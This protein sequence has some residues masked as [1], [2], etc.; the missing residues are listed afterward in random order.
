MPV[1]LAAINANIPKI[2]LLLFL[3]VLLVAGAV[4]GYLKG[5]WRW[6][7]P[8]QVANLKALKNLQ[9]TGLELPGW[10]TL[11]QAV[12]PVSGH[13]WS[14]QQ[15]QRDPQTQAI[16]LLH[17][18]PSSKDQPQVEW[19]DLKGLRWWQS[20]QTRQWKTDRYRRSQITVE[21]QPFKIEAQFFRS[22]I[23]ERNFSGTYAVLQWY[24]WPRGGHPDPSRW[25]WADQIAQWQGRRV[26]WIAVSIMIP[27][28]PLGEIEPV[29][30]LAQSLAQ[31]VQA[32]LIAGPLKGN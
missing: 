20:V 31:T 26:P 3:L 15:I 12:I 4:P 7:A 19:V 27:I 25:F 10:Q 2:I 16:L 14:L 8:P 13:Q 22:W 5:Q 32:A 11:T 21:G 23:Q 29:W 30:P 24:A 18:Q 28:E 9:K 6:Q 17:P 1:K